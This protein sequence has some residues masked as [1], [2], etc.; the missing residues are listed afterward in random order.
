MKTYLKGQRSFILARYNLLTRKQHHGETFEDWNCELR[1]L[2]DLAE[3]EGMT[4][5]DLLKVLITI[6]IRDEKVRSK[7]LEDLGPPTLDETVKMIEQML[8]ASD[9]NARIEK[10]R[11]ESKVSS[12]TKSGSG[13]MPTKTLYQKDKEG[14]Q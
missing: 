6:G 2:Y 5:D 8:Y 4:G 13:K 1:R 7:I 12:I 10:S 9:T 11:G 3:A 14:K